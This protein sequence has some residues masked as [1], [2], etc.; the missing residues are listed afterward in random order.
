LAGKPAALLDKAL[1][2]DPEE[3]QSLVL[4]GLAAMEAKDYRKAITL[5]ERLR[6]QVPE[7]SD[8]AHALD[9]S[10]EKARAGIGK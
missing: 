10:L 3:P 9:A 1:K 2:L 5:W 7:G 8:E 6:K 4:A